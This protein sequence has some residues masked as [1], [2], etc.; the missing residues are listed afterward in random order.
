METLFIL[1][2]LFFIVLIHEAGH[3]IVAKHYGVGVPVFSIGFGPRLIGFKF[4]KGKMAYKI[5]NYKSSN[6]RVWAMPLATEYR[7]AP[8][9][10]GGFCSMRGE[11]HD[12]GSSHDLMSKPYYQ[13]VLVALGGAIANIVTG[14]LA[15]L[16]IVATNVGIVKANYII[17]TTLVSVIKSVAIHTYN[18]FTGVTMLSRWTEITESVSGV[19][20]FQGFVLEFGVLSIIMALFNLLPFP[21][22]DGSLP[23]LWGLE[24][25]LGKKNGELVSSILIAVGFWFLMVVQVLLIFYWVGWI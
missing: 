20:T 9:P 24:K 25:I 5:L 1:S 7:L 23:F 15:L 3:L 12:S 13:K 8:I 22:L 17:Y 16:V 18:L 19:M 4:Y 10:C 6:N 11:G 14:W 21:A 2:V